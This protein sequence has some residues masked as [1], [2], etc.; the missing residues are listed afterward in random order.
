[1]GETVSRANGK[2]EDF[3]D[4]VVD[5]EAEDDA[6]IVIVSGDETKQHSIIPMK[7]LYNYDIG[8]INKY[9]VKYHEKLKK[10]SSTLKG[11]K[12]SVIEVNDTS[13]DVATDIFTGRTRVGHVFL[14]L[15]SWWP[16][17][18]MRRVTSI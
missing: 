3:R 10:Y 4:I 17:P 7:T 6:S 5:L 2:Q 9:D 15:I 14:P 13:M 1:M 18:T 8:V 11:Y 16:R 12:L